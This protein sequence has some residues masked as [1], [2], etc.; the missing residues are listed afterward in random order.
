MSDTKE[1]LMDASGLPVSI[2]IVGMGN[3]DFLPMRILDSDNIF[4]TAPSGRKAQRDIVQFIPFNN[5]LRRGTNPAIGRSHLA[6]EV[7]RE[8]PDQFLGYMKSINNIPKP[9]NCSLNQLPSG[10][11]IE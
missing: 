10:A 11:V 7:L 6:S 3:S 4:L 5:F 2:I 8:V 1:A 9:P